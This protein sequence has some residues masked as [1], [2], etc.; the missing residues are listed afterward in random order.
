MT[1]TDRDGANS[2]QNVTRRTESINS[3]KGFPESWKRL[4]S[5]TLETPVCGI[6]EEIIQPGEFE[7]TF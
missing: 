6:E 1:Q 5:K 2:E 3:L 7:S 4:F